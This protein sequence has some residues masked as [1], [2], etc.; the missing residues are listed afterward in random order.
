MA[1]LPPPP[2]PSE[3]M[4]GP[5]T[6]HMGPHPAKKDKKDKKDKKH[7]K[8]KKEKKEK[9]DKKERK[10]HQRTGPMT[11]AAD[12]LPTT[13]QNAKPALAVHVGGPAASPM[14]GAEV[15]TQ[16]EDDMESAIEERQA[17][18]SPTSEIPTDPLDLLPSAALAP[19][20]AL[21]CKKVEA[22]ATAVL[23]NPVFHFLR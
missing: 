11:N 12:V 16:N 5:L 17:S 2:T 3:P 4:T 22:T 9:K 6:P 7:K 1:E 21:A 19:R 8:D 15:E 23:G 14:Q 20:G 10:E 13:C 18:P